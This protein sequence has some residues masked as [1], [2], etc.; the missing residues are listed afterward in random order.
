MV[1][2]RK[3]YTLKSRFAQQQFPNARFYPVQRDQ[4]Q[5]PGC[6]VEDEVCPRN[7][8]SGVAGK[9]HDCLRELRQEWEIEDRTCCIEQKIGYCRRTGYCA[10]SDACQQGC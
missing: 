2:N 7:G 10:H 9:L 1:K 8:H 3:G 6:Q 4:E 5:Q